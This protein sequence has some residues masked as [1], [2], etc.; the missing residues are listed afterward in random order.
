MGV[1]VLHAYPGGQ[2][3]GGVSP[4]PV[5]HRPQLRQEGNQ[6]ESTDEDGVT[7]DAQQTGYSQVSGELF[8]QG[9]LNFLNR[10]PQWAGAGAD[11]WSLFGDP[12]NRNKTILW[13]M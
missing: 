3:Q 4:H 2:G 13:D 10:R 9:W 6:P 8:V 7:Q 5:H 12:L 1:D 11:K